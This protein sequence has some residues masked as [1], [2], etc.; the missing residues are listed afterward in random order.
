M[1]WVLFFDGDCGFCNRSV[2]RVYALDKEGAIDFAPLQGDLAKQMGLEKFA[3]KDGGT[4]VMLRESDGEEFYKGDAWIVLGE[5]LGGVWAML[6]RVF[7]VFP[8]TSR[9]WGYDRVAKNRYL[10]AGKNDSCG[11]PEEGLRERMRG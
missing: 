2:R 5:A 8:K 10:L 6:A 4:M 3:D 9:D 7:A 11:M 1:A